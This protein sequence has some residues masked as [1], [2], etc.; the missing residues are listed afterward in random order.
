MQKSAELLIFDKIPE[1]YR[2]QIKCGSG[3]YS[4]VKIVK[5]EGSKPILTGINVSISGGYIQFVA[6]DG[7]RLAIIILVAHLHSLV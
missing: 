2:T 7:F 1:A 6:I 4:S 3:S 5:S